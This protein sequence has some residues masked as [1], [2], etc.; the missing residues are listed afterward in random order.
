LQ[1]V[2]ERHEGDVPK[3]AREVARQEQERIERPG[4]PGAPERF[5]ALQALP[6]YLLDRCG[7]N[8]SAQIPADELVERFRIPRESL[9]EHLSLLHLV[10]FVGGCYAAYAATRGHNR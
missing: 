2:R 8:T 6:A 3:L 1:Q 9:E 7:E 4:A 10:N 5:G